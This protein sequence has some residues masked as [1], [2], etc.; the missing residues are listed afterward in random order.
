M[1]I[2]T[3]PTTPTAELEEVSIS[4]VRLSR[5]LLWAAL[6]LAFLTF[7]GSLQYDFVYDD[8]LQVR[9]N[10]VIR[11]WSQ[12]P[13]YFKHN[14][15]Y[16]VTPDSAG[17]YYRPGFQLWLLLNFKIGGTSSVYWHLSTVLMHVLV[18]WLIF[19]L[20]RTL[21]RNDLSAAIAALVFAVH[22]VHI[23][24]V[25]WI[26]GVT[27]PLLAAL[28]LPS[29]Y[30]YIRWRESGGRLYFVYSL[31]LYLASTTVK[32][33][34]VVMPMIIAVY[35]ILYAPAKVEW[36]RKLQRSATALIPFILIT[37][38]Y[39]LV[40]AHVLTNFFSTRPPIPLDS[41]LMTIP[42]LVVLYC[43]HLVYP[44]GLSIFYDF[45]AISKASDPRLWGGVL[46]VV[47][48][49]A[50]VY[51][52]WKKW[53]HPAVGYA[54]AIFLI[55]LSPALYGTRYLYKGELIHD[56]YLY[57]PLFGFCLLTGMA[58]ERWFKRRERKSG[59][60]M[61][62]AGALTL[63]VGILGIT[64]AVEEIHWA[65][66]LLMFY[67][68]YKIAPNNL[69][70]RNGLASALADRHNTGQAMVLYRE[71]LQMDPN[72]WLTNLNFGIFLLNIGQNEEAIHLFSR[73]KEIGKG[74]G[75][76]DFFI[77]VANLHEGNLQEAEHYL[78][79]AAGISP[80]QPEVH[81]VLA[82]SLAMQ[83][84]FPEAIAEMEKAIQLQ[85]SP[86][87]SEELSRLKGLQS[88]AQVPK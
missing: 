5:W 66:N 76:Y 3:D 6:V 38:A 39:L 8:A 41:T 37:A 28:M 14:V 61:L 44:Y 26:S 17:I 23:E 72:F 36:R 82:E 11:D 52:L 15:W 78:R 29:L 22:P 12:A 20:S 10:P 56:R 31:L 2:A 7:F 65:N 64:T 32:E 58:F 68:A 81:R 55:I 49:F 50:G 46:G 18:V 62:K 16:P 87:L 40:R 53:R 70:S 42:W 33:T 35:D 27:D 80:G 19:V 45:D 48:L 1:S 75:N 67:R 59:R 9:Q 71:T 60:V 79:S 54:L 74:K 30:F 51:W 63:L 57:L 34:A 13:S 83:K 25:A 47:A 88:G 85:P 4:E 73:A 24:S 84:K 43:K 69:M 86:A 77:G 21:V